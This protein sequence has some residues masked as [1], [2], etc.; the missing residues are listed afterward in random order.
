RD[1]ARRM[2]EFPRTLENRSILRF[3]L[4]RLACDTVVDRCLFA[5]ARPLGLLQNLVGKAQDHFEAAL[6]IL[7]EYDELDTSPKRGLR[8]LNWN[9]VLRRAGQFANAAQVQAK[10]NEAANRRVAQD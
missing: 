3:A 4:E 7:D 6:A 9:E 5:V 1:V 8:A 10:K 2:L